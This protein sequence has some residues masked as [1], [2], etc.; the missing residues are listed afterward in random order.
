M[1]LTLIILAAGMGSRYGGLKQLD[2][3]GTSDETIMEYAI[4]DALQCGF[5]KVVFVIRRDMLAAFSQQFGDKISAYIQVEYV[6]Q[7]RSAL[8]R[9]TGHS[10]ERDKPWGTTHALLAAQTTVQT[11]FCVINADDFYGRNAYLLAA[12]ALS[13]QVLSATA[14]QTIS[15]G[16]MI[17]YPLGSVLSEYGAVSRGLCQTDAQNYL[18]SIVEATSVEKQTDGTITAQGINQ[19]LSRETY[20]SMNFWGFEPS[21]FPLL[22]NLF[23]EFLATHQNDPKAE[24]YISSTVNTL[25]ERQL[26]SVKILPNTQANWMGVTYQADKPLVAQ[27]LQNYTTK[28]IYPSSLW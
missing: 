6:F 26:L 13:A 9:P 8:H 10:I 5:D 2:K 11:S 21:I 20:T 14:Q 25:I 4:Y 3:F 18:Q 7:E 16:F 27:T 24:C 28:G 19:Q 15:N 12:Q 17:G 22:A 23:D 1:S